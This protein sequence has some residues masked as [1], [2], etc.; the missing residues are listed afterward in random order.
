MSTVSPNRDTKS[1]ETPPPERAA[2]LYAIARVF[3]RAFFRLV[4]RWEVTGRQH[5]PPEGGVL[6]IANHTS[7]ADPP[8]VGTAC[9]RPVNFMAKAELF[10]IPVLG[11]L[12]RR[13]HAFPVRRGSTDREALRRAVRLLRQRRVLLV[14]PEGTRSPDG[15]LMAAEHGAAFIALSGEAQVVPVAID[16]ADHLLPRHSPIIR[17]AKLRVTFG[18]PVALSDLH[19]QRL[20]RDVL[21]QAS[22]RMMTALRDLLPPD[23]R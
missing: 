14:F 16:G 21:G 23:R 1:Q 6:L 20:T 10:G 8:I 2:P 3:L 11:W 15:R 18:A 9:P 19:G 5:V 7:Y 22:E 13:T 12:I 4:A 17:P